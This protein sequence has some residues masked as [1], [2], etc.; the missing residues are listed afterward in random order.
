M[1]GFSNQNDSMKFGGV[2]SQ[3]AQEQTTNIGMS[4]AFGGFGQ[5]NEIG[6]GM[7][8]GL[9]IGLGAQPSTQGS[10]NMFGSGMQDQPTGFQ[11]SQNS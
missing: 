10:S 5:S 11:E 2:N 3:E 6:F 9:G 1:F 7:G 8:M 4:N